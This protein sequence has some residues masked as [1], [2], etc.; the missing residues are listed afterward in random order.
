[1]VDREESLSRGRRAARGVIG[2]LVGAG[3]CGLLWLLLFEVGFAPERA[4]ERLADV[5]PVLLGWL[6]AL[7][8]IWGVWGRA[9]L[10]VVEE[11]ALPEGLEPGARRLYLLGMVVAGLAV[12]QYQVT[13]FILRDPTDLPSFIFAA[14]AMAAGENFYDLEVI[15][16]FASEPLGNRP[17]FPYLYLP[18]YALLLRPVALLTDAGAHAFFLMVNLVLWP[19]LI[20]LVL[21]LVEAPRHLR[22]PLFVL[23]IL[24][25]HSY[26]PAIQTFHHGS[27]SV[28][29]AVLVIG[30]LVA[31]RAERARLAGLLLALAVLIKIVPVFLVLYLLLRRRFA[32]VKWGLISGAALMALSL[33]IVGV[34]PH[35]HWLTQMVPGLAYGASTGTFFEPG[36]HPENQ[37]LTGTFCR[38][39]GAGSGIYQKAASVTGALLLLVVG[40]ALWRRRPGAIDR[41][42]SSLVVVTILLVSTIT[43]FHHMT[44]MLLP[45]LTLIVAG[46]EG[47]GIGARMM[48]AVGAVALV[49]V[50]FEFYLDPWPFV[51][52]NP[53]T[54]SIRFQVMFLCWVA[55]V[56]PLLRRTRPAEASA[57]LPP[58]VL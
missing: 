47:K 37:S 32:V 33:L 19:L 14:R 1:M 7:G 8:A 31:A 38:F 20:L 24:V 46:A 50:G 48:L 49:V 22:G 4:R 17:I 52:P 51:A 12:I 28:L 45:A 43:W 16:G 27:P 18:L 26:L 36:C 9:L 57:E 23:V 15:R 13:A 35:L 2:A 55:L 58:R 5:G 11:I 44:M 30:T 39:L 56:V 54:R 29:V 6:M 53:L 40:F 41:L 25:M 10:D 21:R 34:E 3:L 42:E